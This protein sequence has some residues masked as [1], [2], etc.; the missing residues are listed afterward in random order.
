MRARTLRA[1]LTLS[2]AGALA[3]FVSLSGLTYYQVFAHQLDLDA[4][5]E[6]RELTDG[7]HGYLRF[8]AGVPDLMYDRND[9]EEVSFVQEATTYYQVYDARTGRLLV[10]SPA[11]EPLGVSYTPGE[12]RSLVRHPG[13]HDVQTGQRRIRMS[14]S[15]IAPA[16]GEEYLLQVGVPLD[17]RDGALAR[18]LSLLLW[19]LPA[20]LFAVVAIGRWMAAR[21]LSPL[22]R[23]ARAA[24]TI[25][26]DDLHRRLPVRG[27]GDELDAVADAFNA[28][29]SRLEH[30]V[31]EMKQFSAAMAHELRTPLAALRGEMELALRHSRSPAEY[32]R[33]LV[34]QLEEIDKLARLIGQLLTLARADA[35]QIPLARKSVNLGALS[36]DLLSDL[37]P[38]AHAKGLTLECQCPAD[39]FVTGDAEWIE[40]MLIN[41]VDNAMKFTPAGGRISLSVARENGVARLEVRDTGIG[42]SAGVLAHAF[43]RFYQADSARSSDNEGA[44][45]GLSLVKW[46]ADRHEAAIDIASRVDEGTIVT[47]RLPLR[48]VPAE[49][50]HHQ[51]RCA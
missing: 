51:V 22:A 37:E 47:L 2:Y 34:S 46:I 5:A 32:Q 48:T 8:H 24:R 10:R 44:G 39:V 6:L 29:V 43:E 25:G 30:S 11:L 50:V 14:S 3:I 42:M 19:S 12:V 16:P 33:A 35:G 7:V 27:T 41:L 18:F 49:A 23:L 15:L 13:I 28:V 4:D 20:G 31:S 45:L 36:A 26:V 40:R 1:T 21:A 38:V 17:Q 9:P